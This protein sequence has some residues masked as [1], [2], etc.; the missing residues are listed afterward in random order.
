MLEFF[1]VDPHPFAHRDLANFEDALHHFLCLIEF[2]KMHQ[3]QEG[4]GAHFLRKKTSLRDLG[5]LKILE[6]PHTHDGKG[7]ILQFETFEVSGLAHLP[8]SIIK[9]GQFEVPL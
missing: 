1:S 3:H 4:F 2:E 7:T 8:T 9:S 6:E 5:H